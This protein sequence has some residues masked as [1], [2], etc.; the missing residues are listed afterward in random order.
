MNPDEIK[1]QA[2][3]GESMQTRQLGKNGP[4]LSV[5]GLGTWAIGGPWQWGWG[6]QND[7]DSIAAIRTSLEN[8]VNWIDAAPVYGL[9]HAEEIVAKAVQDFR[10]DEVFIATK[11]GLVWDDRRR[12]QIHL[13]PESIRKEIEHS[14]RRLKV[15]Q[16][17]LY[18]HHWPDPNTSLDASWGEMVRLKEGGKVRYIGVCNYDAKLLEKCGKI[19]RVQSLQ[20][21]L[22]LVKRDYLDETLPYCQENEIGVVAYSPLQTGLLTGK[23]NKDN[24]AKDDWRSRGEYFREPRLSKILDF[25]EKLRPVAENC[26]FEVLHLAITWVLAQMAVTSAIVGSRTAEQALANARAAEL[27]LTQEELSRIEGFLRELE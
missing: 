19:Y 20:P 12:V 22:S 6:P 14:L 16:I 21:P 7:A 23:F 27:E 13:G 4:S 3:T 25:V 9:G 26:G 18:Q 24:L 17:D 8:G 11:C 2:K 1:N 5:I 10:R 15:E